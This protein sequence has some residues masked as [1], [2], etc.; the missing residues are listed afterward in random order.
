M[1]TI[2]PEIPWIPMGG[3]PLKMAGPDPF[4]PTKWPRQVASLE[5]SAGEVWLY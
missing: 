2:A 3:A 4:V 1:S 5:E